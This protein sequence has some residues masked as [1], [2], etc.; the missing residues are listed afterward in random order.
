[1]KILKPVK[2]LYKTRYEIKIGPCYIGLHFWKYSIYIPR[3][4]SK[5]IQSRS[6]VAINAATATGAF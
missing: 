3:A 5:R 2:R 6:K 1:M 4:K